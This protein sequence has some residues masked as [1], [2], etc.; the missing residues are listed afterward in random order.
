MMDTWI[1]WTLGAVLVAVLFSFMVWFV[2]VRPRQPQLEA[3][4]NSDCE[5]M[6]TA[7]IADSKIIFRN[8][9][10]FFWRT[11]R[12]RDES[13]I[14]EVTVDTEEIKDIWFIVDHFHSLHGLAHTYLTFEF[15]DGTCLS[16]SFEARRRVKHRYHP[17]DGLWRNYELYLLVALESDMTGLR[18]N[19]RGNKDYMFRA[20]TPP[21][22]DKH[23]L[24][25]MAQKANQLS[26]KP[27]WY[28]S[29]LTT[30]NTS[31]VRMVNRVTPGRVPFLWRNFLP[32]YTPR[33]ALKL[34]LIEDW[35]GL[36]MTLEKARIDLIA[37]QWDG[38]GSYSEMLRRHLPTSTVEKEQ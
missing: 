19:A 36:E 17:W 29:L 18:T 23:M 34:G 33:A 5:L 38:E 20:I 1:E 7:D 11:T 10:N 31:I 32:G 12:D 30:C 4:W 2:R 27:E 35:G 16:F 21:E 25:R 37:Q 8:V 22:K 28:H 13:W 14:D 6:T 26:Q 9:R 24:I 15:N 3:E